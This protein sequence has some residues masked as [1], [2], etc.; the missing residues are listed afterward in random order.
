MTH[1]HNTHNTHITQQTHNTQ[2]TQ[3]TTNTHAQHTTHTHTTHN[4]QHTRDTDTRHNTTHTRMLCVV[5]V[6]CVLSTTHVG[7]VF[8]SPARGCCLI[9]L[10]VRDVLKRMYQL[11][12]WKEKQ[13]M[14]DRTPTKERFP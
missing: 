13:P 8:V 5:I 1:H 14:V 9:T 4:T 2:H 12:T 11:H 7:C 10:P 3:H 6:C